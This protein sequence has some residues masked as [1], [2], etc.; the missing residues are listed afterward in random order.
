MQQPLLLA[1]HTCRIFIETKQRL[2]PMLHATHNWR[3]GHEQDVCLCMVCRLRLSAWKAAICSPEHLCAVLCAE[4]LCRSGAPGIFMLCIVLY[5]VTCT[6]LC[7]C[8]MESY[9]T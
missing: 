9:N 8:S 3:E 4:A 1:C 7:L 6:V 5:G 2:G